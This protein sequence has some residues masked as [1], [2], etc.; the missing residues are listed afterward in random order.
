MSK[1]LIF[2][3]FNYKYCHKKLMK[4]THALVVKLVDTKDLKVEG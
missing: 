2:P 3:L 1:N 4:I